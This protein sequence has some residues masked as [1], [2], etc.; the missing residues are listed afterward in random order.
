MNR[1]YVTASLAVAV[2]GTAI[3]LVPT[4]ASASAPTTTAT[5]TAA[6]ASQTSST[7]LGTTHFLTLAAADKAADAAISACLA[8]GYP[9]SV[10]VVDRDGNVI[11]QQR[12]DTATGATL[13]VSQGKADAAVG[14]QVPSSE[15]QNLAATDPGVIYI[16]GF[17]ILPGGLPITLDGSVVA[18]LGV[19]GSPTATIDTSCATAGVNAIS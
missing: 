15:I 16:P 12:A 8:K 19:S 6:P 4:L 9:V 18:G 2:A 1:K 3:A 17:S 11:T 14:F 10:S 13:Q 7:E 5:A